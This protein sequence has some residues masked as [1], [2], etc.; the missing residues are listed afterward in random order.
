VPGD[1][2][3]IS[4]QFGFLTDFFKDNKKKCKVV[5]RVEGIREKQETFLYR[6]ALKPISMQ[7]GREIFIRFPYRSYGFDS[8]VITLKVAQ[9]KGFKR[10]DHDLSRQGAQLA[11][12]HLQFN[13]E[14]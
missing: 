14:H 4:W 10:H 13:K 2:S 3:G 9:Q 5:L 7:R 12:C 8:L 11:I 6:K 1:A